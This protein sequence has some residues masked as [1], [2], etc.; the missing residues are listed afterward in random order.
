VIKILFISLLLLFETGWNIDHALY[1]SVTEVVV[2][3]ENYSITVKVFSDDLFSCMYNRDKALKSTMDHLVDTEIE[4]YFADHLLIQEDEKSEPLTLVS[5]STEGDSYFLHFSQVRSKNS[6]LIKI[7]L[8]YFY[9]LFP[10]QR[11]IL[12]VKNDADQQHRIFKSKDQ[13]ESFQLSSLGQ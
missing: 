2:A 6:D 12:K 7:Q 8:R 10:T 13:I 5:F 4:A 9:E 11:N 1:L 3:Q